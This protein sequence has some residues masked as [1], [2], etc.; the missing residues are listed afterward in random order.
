MRVPGETSAAS[1]DPRHLASLPASSRV[2]L[3]A[4]QSPPSDTEPK[5]VV[6]APVTVALTFAAPSAAR[7][8]ET[9]RDAPT[10]PP[11]NA[12]S[13]AF[14]NLAAGTAIL[15]GHRRF[16]EGDCDHPGRRP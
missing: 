7:T 6:V 16:I 15:V 14:P 2:Q 4:A 8:A 12:L 13:C 1:S 9:P 3:V 5:S 10:A 11:Q